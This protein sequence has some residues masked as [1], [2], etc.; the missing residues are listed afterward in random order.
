MIRGTTPTH[1][2]SVPYDLTNVENIVIRYGQND[3]PLF[4]KTKADCII[5]GNLIT[6]TLTEEETYSFDCH[7]VGQAQI[8]LTF[9]GGE[10]IKSEI[11]LFSVGRCL[12][13]GL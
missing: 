9:I 5:A 11:M 6:V 8:E 1:S 3:K 4:E 10:K 2:F 12:K 13:G 7:F